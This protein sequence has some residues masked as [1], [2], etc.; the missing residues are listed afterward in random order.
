[1]VRHKEFVEEQ[2]REW[3]RQQGRWKKYDVWREQEK[4]RRIEIDR[5]IA[6]MVSGIDVHGPVAHRSG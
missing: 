4:Q 1:M 6:Q 3:Q 2:N 5:R